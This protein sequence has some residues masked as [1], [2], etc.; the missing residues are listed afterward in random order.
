MINNEELNWTTIVPGTAGIY[1][2]TNKV[3]GKEYVG[4]SID[5]RKRL[6]QH[7]RSS[8]SGSAGL[9]HKALRKYGKHNFSFSYQTCSLEDDLSSLEISE[10]SLRNSMAPIGYN[11]TAG[12]DGAV[13]YKHTEESR[14]K[15]KEIHTG[16]VLPEAQKE[17]IRKALKGRPRP[18]DVV[19]KIRAGNTGKVHSSETRA[20]LSVTSKGNK[21]AKR[22]AVQVW[23]QDCL[24]PKYFCTKKDAANY[25]GVFVETLN[26]WL[27]GEIQTKRSTSHHVQAL[28]MST[29]VSYDG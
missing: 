22:Y 16:R 13:G 12:G 2:F 21:S 28:K 5:L 19:A 11:L 29:A 8:D 17:A 18:Q 20:L 27:S 14:A 9:L 6:R 15:L 10:I 24:I 3:N 7:L 25:L 1:V 23:E 26:R 4:K